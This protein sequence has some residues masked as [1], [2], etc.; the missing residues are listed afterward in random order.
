MQTPLDY[1]LGANLENLT[2]LSSAIKGTGNELANSLVGNASN[3][4]LIGGLGNDTINGSTGVDVMQGGAD[5]DILSDTSG[6]NLFDGGSG[7]DTLT[8]GV[9]NELFVGGTGND[10]IT[11]ST[12]FDVIAF[13]YGDGQDIINASTGKDNTISLGGAGMNYANLNFHRA[14]NDLILDVGEANQLTLKSWYA[15]ATNKSV[16]KLQVIEEA[17]VGYNPAAVDPLLNK[18]VQVFDFTTLVNAFDT[19]TGGAS[20]V[21]WALTN[22]LLAAHLAASSGDAAALGGELAYYYGKNNTLAGVGFTP[23]QSILNTVGFGQNVQAFLPVGQIT[24][25]TIKLS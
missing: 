12:G 19:A 4:L 16:A 25:G 2:L 1:V 21:N 9:S 5:N 10:T 18:K 7:T 22:Q 20:N 14:T 11:T 8:G 17:M 13:N 24:S 23:A 3:N 6:V 15:A